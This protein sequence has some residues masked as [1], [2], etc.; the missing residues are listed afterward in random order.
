MRSGVGSRYFPTLIFLPYSLCFL[1]KEIFATGVTLNRV[2]SLFKKN[3]AFLRGEAIASITNKPDLLMVS[4]IHQRKS[5]TRV[6]NLNFDERLTLKE[7]EESTG[8]LRNEK[9]GD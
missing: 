7:T 3:I 1:A 6:F 4:T 9:D 8:F 2:G 5:Q